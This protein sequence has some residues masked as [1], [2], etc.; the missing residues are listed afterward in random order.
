MNLGWT[1]RQVLDSTDWYGM[2][3]PECKG[4]D[5]DTIA[6]EKIRWLQLLKDFDCTVTSTWTNN[7]DNREF[8]TW[9][10]WG[11]RVCK[12]QLDYIM[13]TKDIC[14]TT[15]YLNK[16]RLRTWDHF[17]VTTKIEGRELG[18]EKG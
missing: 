10:A 14:S 3:G 11:S 17:F 9:R 7:E 4:C 12:K 13:G 8:H 5:E 6:H 18:M 2:Y 15:W 1:T 16:A